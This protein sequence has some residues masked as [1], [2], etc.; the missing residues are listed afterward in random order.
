MSIKGRLIL[1]TAG[2][3]AI[4][5]MMFLF[6]W[7][8]TTS[9]KDDGLVI[10]LA[11]RQRMLLQKMTKEAAAFAISKSQS[12]GA[13]QAL[14]AKA[15]RSEVVFDTTLNALRDS[16]EAPLALTPDAATRHVGKA[17]EPAYS[18]LVK[19]TELWR[20]YQPRLEAVINDKGGSG[21]D[22][23]W[24]IANSDS[25]VGEMDKAV[26]MLQEMSEATVTKL[27]VEQAVSL[28][29]AVVIALMVLLMTRS[30]IL[31]LLAVR[32]FAEKFGA[33]DLT[34]LSGISGSDELANIGADLD[35]MAVKLRKM[36][37]ELKDRA[38]LLNSSSG[39]LTHISSTMANETDRMSGLS[40]TVAA[41]SEEMSANMNS[42]AA[43]MEEA[44]TNVAMVAAASEEMSS[45]VQ[46][47]SRNTDETKRLSQS[48][49]ED[50]RRVCEEVDALGNSAMEIGKVTEA[51]AEIS[52]Q[53]KLLAL[54]ATIEAARAGE[55]GKG[56]AVVASEIKSLAQQT[57]KATAEIG[58][59]ISSI[60][61]TTRTAVGAI[62]KIASD[63]GNID[64][65]IYTV[66]LAMGEQARTTQDIA[67]NVSEAAKGIQEVN[68]TVVE[69]SMVTREIT[70]DIAMMDN[71]LKDMSRQGK[72]VETN[73]TT[74]NSLGS[75]MHE[76]VQTFKI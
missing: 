70:K 61:G 22:L 74:L 31:R 30:I 45:N 66:A 67:Q 56:F 72:E 39:Q 5:A 52:E 68:R 16:G 14:S 44:S 8:A 7:L 32:T 35:A 18:Q 50:A 76:S 28:A 40:T 43:A 38:Y 11:G 9:Q 37:A 63:V 59:K 1:S 46:E 27:L 34:A 13:D 23:K 12:G 25:I 10:N 71:G 26:V 60:Q 73:A 51:I 65:H 54:N 21:E 33:G 41:A 19:V 24:L 58:D 2:F 55:A 29:L 49:V 15:R 57:A 3:S 48:A 20:Q 36:F 64:S 17:D 75:Q 69:C 47:I 62:Q 53:T 4:I 6:T 42:V